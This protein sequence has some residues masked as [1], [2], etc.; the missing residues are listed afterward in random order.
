[1][2][3][4]S[5]PT[6][7]RR[8]STRFFVQRTSDCQIFR[9]LKNSCR[10]LHVFRQ[11]IEL[12]R[13]PVAQCRMQPSLVVSP[14]QERPHSPPHFRST[15]T[16]SGKPG[17]G[18][19]SL[20]PCARRSSQIRPEVARSSGRHGN[21]QLC[22]RSRVNPTCGAPGLRATDW[23]VGGCPRSDLWESP[24]GWDYGPGER[25][26]QPAR[27]RRV[28]CR[29]S[30]GQLAQRLPDRREANAQACTTAP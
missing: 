29:R 24:H 2:G 14:L 12:R 3:L 22:A 17:D 30:L 20:A 27:G 15:E 25:R 18:A 16:A 6:N 7:G 26:F 13:R 8:P 5:K 10:N 23:I 11:A 28:Q 9:C 4:G 21:C 19:F 1:M